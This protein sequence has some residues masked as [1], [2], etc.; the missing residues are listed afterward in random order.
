SPAVS[1]PATRFCA[2]LAHRSLIDLQFARGAGPRMQFGPRV[3]WDISRGRIAPTN[4]VH[5]WLMSTAPATPAAMA[6]WAR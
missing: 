4:M 5:P 3:T 6:A 1:D 2:P